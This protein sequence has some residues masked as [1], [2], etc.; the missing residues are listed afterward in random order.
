MVFINLITLS[1]EILETE[2][3]LK[4]KIRQT[5]KNGFNVKKNSFSKYH[6]N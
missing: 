5:D 3:T 4:K 6:T 1:L 2:K